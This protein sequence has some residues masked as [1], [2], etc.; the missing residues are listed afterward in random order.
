MESR[1][2]WSSS[3]VEGAVHHG[4][5][6]STHG[7]DYSTTF[8][9]YTAKIIVKFDFVL[10]VVLLFVVFLFSSFFLLFVVHCVCDCSCVCM[11]CIAIM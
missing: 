10:C 7:S 5:L 2:L 1:E 11:D 3:G 8:I 6:V 9:F 4:I